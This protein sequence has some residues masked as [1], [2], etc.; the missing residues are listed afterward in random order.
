MNFHINSIESFSAHPDGHSC[1]D[2]EPK[3]SH[4]TFVQLYSRVVR[5]GALG[6]HKTKAKTLFQSRATRS[7][8]PHR[9]HSLTRS[10]FSP[11]LSLCT[12]S[13]R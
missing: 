12:A 6:K 1:L 5:S 8:A 3:R 10:F 9:S 11:D 4:I 13:P 2:Y 7:H